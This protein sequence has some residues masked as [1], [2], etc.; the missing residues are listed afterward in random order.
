M[1]LP[2]LRDHPGF[3]LS[4]VCAKTGL[5]VRG[6]VEK[7]GFGRGSTDYREVVAA[8]DVDLVYVV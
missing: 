8:H 7:D 2:L 3:T 1:L 5:T 4:T 6:A